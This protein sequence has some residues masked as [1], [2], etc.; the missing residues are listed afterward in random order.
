MVKS[1]QSTRRPPSRLLLLVVLAAIG[2]GL[3]Y[4]PDKLVQQ[5]QRAQQLGPVWGYLY[6]GFVGTGCVLLIVSTSWTFYRLVRASRRKRVRKEQLA[7]NPS[8]LSAAEREREIASNLSA[9]TGYK[10]DPDIDVEVREELEPLVGRLEQK[11]ESQALEIVAFGTISSGKSSVLNALA[12]RDLFVTDARGGTTTQ[13]NEIAWPGHDRVTLVD[14]PGLDEVDGETRHAVAADAAKNADLVLLVVDGPLRDS[15]HV[16]LQQLSKMEKRILVCLNKEDWYTPADQAK[17]LRQIATQVQ[18]MVAAD[19]ILAVRAQPGIRQRTRVLANGTEVDESVPVEPDIGQLADRMLAVAKRNGSDLLL[20]N[21]L[22]QSRG[23]V[24]RAKERVQESLDKKA[25][26]IVDR[27]M[28]SAGGAAALSPFPFVDLAAGVAISSKMVIDLARVYR[29]EMDTRIAV[30]LLGQQGKNLIGVLGANVATP[31]VASLIASSLKTV[32][33][34]GTITGGLLQGIVQALV[35]RWIGAVFIKYFK[36]EM[37]EPPGGLAGLARREWEKLTTV[38]EL[39][40]LV[41]AARR[42]MTE[43]EE[44]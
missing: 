17:L 1:T 6:L 39:R 16:M 20:A 10:S 7:K 31:A 13:R 4:L 14:T 21:L 35:T 9:V 34:I 27:Y 23:L 19:D 37:R 28:W 30:D 36:N 43:D 25:A 26:D 29:Q 8:E 18:S 5:Y 38:S 3:V 33:G 2:F 41:R 11:Q 22:L 40:N 44:E 12:G 15:E 42:H 24:D 32:P